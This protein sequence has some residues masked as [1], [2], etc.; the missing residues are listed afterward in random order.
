MPSAYLIADVDVHDPVA[1][2]DYRKLSTLA[3]Q[4]HG[5]EVCIRGGQVEVLE[6]DWQP[7][8][9]VMLK[10]PSM[11]AARRFHDSPEYR[12]ARAVRE[13]VSTMRM[14]IVAGV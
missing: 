12:K 5:A 3:M 9:V 8:R 7:K 1:Y 13:P 10:F 14:I 2:E 6:G 4:A 11:E